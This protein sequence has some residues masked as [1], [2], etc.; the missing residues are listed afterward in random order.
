[1]YVSRPMAYN[2]SVGEKLIKY[3]IKHYHQI[4]EDT[5]LLII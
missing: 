5:C 3:K 4:S 2:I 1:M